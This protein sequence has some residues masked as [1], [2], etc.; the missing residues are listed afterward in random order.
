MTETAA[1]RTAAAISTADLRQLIAA[2]SP[3]KLIDVRTPGEFDSGHIPGAENIPLDRVKGLADKIGAG[4]AEVVLICQGG[5]RAEMARGHLSGADLPGAVVLTGGMNAWS[6]CGGETTAA[7][8]SRWTLER[9]V[10]FVAGLL[11]LVG[12]LVSIAWPPARFFSG[13]IG[14]GLVFAAVTNTCMMGIMLG[15][16]PY[17]RGRSCDID[18]AVTRLSKN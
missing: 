17:N 2:G 3:V 13:A 1:G 7:N 12:I 10:R 6:G 15:K 8:S 16:L 14:F 9:Q 11:V 4:S 18:A 5:T